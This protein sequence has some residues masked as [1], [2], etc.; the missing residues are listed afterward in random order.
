MQLAQIKAFIDAMASSDLAELEV[1]RDGWTLRLARRHGQRAPVRP[2]AD[3][4]PQQTSHR[5]AELDAV[6]PAP[7][8]TSEIVA[9]EIMA[10][11]AG[12]VYLQP[13]PGQPPYVVAGQAIKAGTA[14]CIIEA[15]KTMNEIRAEHDG[16]IEAILVASETLVEAGQPLMRIT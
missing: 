2:A 12:I 7:V 8:A 6:A 1:S 14:V 3:P 10:P 9:R 5:E 16:T 13:S 15:M 4:R 11:L